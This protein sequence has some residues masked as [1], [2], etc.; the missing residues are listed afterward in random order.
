[1]RISDWSSDVC[2][3]DL[4]GKSSNKSARSETLA[5]GTYRL[6]RSL[7]AGEQRL[8]L[9]H[10]PHFASLETDIDARR[11]LLC[12]KIRSEERR[13]GKEGVRKGRSRWSQLNKKKK[14]IRQSYSHLTI[15]TR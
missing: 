3:S 14:N 9:I 11:R 8:E 12:V 15:V 5:I 7:V 10:F 13:V 4:R 2:S 1:M 6:K